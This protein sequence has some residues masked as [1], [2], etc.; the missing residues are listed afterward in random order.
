MNEFIEI[1]KYKLIGK[2]SLTFYIP[3]VFATYL[4][5]TQLVKG[6][7]IRLKRAIRH[8]HRYKTFKTVNQS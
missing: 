7:K 1:F 5:D 8:L 4:V 2:L 3:T 6:V